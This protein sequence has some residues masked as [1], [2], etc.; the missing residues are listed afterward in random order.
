ML[1]APPVTMMRR[2]A[3]PRKFRLTA[4]AESGGT[5]H[6]IMSW[7]GH[8]TLSE[9]E[10]YTRSANRRALVMGVEQEQNAV[11]VSTDASKRADK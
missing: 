8:A 7:G 2:P 1:W 6:A 3:R 10:H 5:A 9:A 4:I 11:N